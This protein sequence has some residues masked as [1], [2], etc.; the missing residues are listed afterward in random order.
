MLERTEGLRRSGVVLDV[1]VV[2]E[3]S[4]NP[5]V[6]A[7]ITWA[8]ERIEKMAREDD[9]M[10]V[11]LNK[12]VTDGDKWQAV[13]TENGEVG[14]I[15]S[16]HM[17]VKGI[18][19]R[20]KNFAWHQGILDQRKEIA[21]T[22]DGREIE[23]SGIVI[24][25]KDSRGGLYFYMDQEPTAAIQII[26]G[27]ELHP[28]I[29]APQGSAEKLDRLDAGEERVDP[30]LFRIQQTLGKTLRQIAGEVR[31]ARIDDPSKVDSAVY[32]GAYQVDEEMAT[33]LEELGGRFLGPESRRALTPL[34]NAHAHVAVSVAL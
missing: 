5:E 15:K 7:D 12:P 28:S 8:R 27:K 9:V 21:A 26:D 1:R 3:I 22:T 10:E 13:M 31:T 6:A 11:V 17:G 16:A 29:K 24:A 34:M 14:E 33:R 4:D 18:D 30:M 2:P 19:V 32:F 23:V 20:R 25:L